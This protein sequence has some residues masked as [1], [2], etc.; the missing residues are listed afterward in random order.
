MLQP[1]SA[2]LTALQ[3]HFSFEVAI[4]MNGAVWIRAAGDSA[5]DGIAIR[6]A[7]INA[8]HLDDA[9]INAM[10]DQIAKR[11]KNVKTK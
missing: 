6:N 8:E 2:L 10:V 1:D 7:V 3:R 4:G 11:S 9:E 5:V